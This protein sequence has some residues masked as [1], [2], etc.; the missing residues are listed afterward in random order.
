LRKNLINSPKFFLDKDLK[1]VKLYAS[2]VFKNLKFLY[3]LQMGHET[4]NTKEFKFEFESN[5][6]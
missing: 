6:N 4:E 3:K 1:N 2:L 5:V